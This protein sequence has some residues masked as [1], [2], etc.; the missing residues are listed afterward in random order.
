M[1]QMQAIPTLLNQLRSNGRFQALEAAA[2]LY[3]L[4]NSNTPGVYEAV[5][6]AGGVAA[7]V[8]AL[9]SASAQAGGEEPFYTLPASL[10]R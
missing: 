10:R 8:Q 1:L 6:A 4:A 5:V 7:I 9:R 2:K 3:N